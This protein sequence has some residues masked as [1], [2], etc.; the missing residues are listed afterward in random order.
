MLYKQPSQ[1]VQ[2]CVNHTHYSKNCYLQ[3]LW[4]KTT[5]SLWPKY[6]VQMIFTENFLWWVT[7][8]RTWP[9]AA[10][11]CTHRANHMEYHSR[12]HM[13]LVV[14]LGKL[15]TTFCVNFALQRHKIH[16][17]SL[18]SCKCTCDCSEN[19]FHFEFEEKESVDFSWAC[20]S[21]PSFIDHLLF[22]TG[23]CCTNG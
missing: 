23:F 17:I 15:G 20:L 2:C 4:S 5:R 12:V 22:K 18:N 19:G 10:R 6:H 1:E 7:T 21:D 16:C 13:Y 11:F 8:C 14:R 9:V 3:S